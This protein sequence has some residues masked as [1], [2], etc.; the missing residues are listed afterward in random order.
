MS[1]KKIREEIADLEEAIKLMDEDG[2]DTSDMKEV[3]ANLKADLESDKETLKAMAKKDKAKTTSQKISEG[4][5]AK[6]IV[7]PKG[8]PKAVKD[9]EKIAKQLSKDS[10]DKKGFHKGQKIIDKLSVKAESKQGSKLYTYDVYIIQSDY[11]PKGDIYKGY[12]LS[13]DNTPATWL[14]STLKESNQSMD[15]ISIHG[16]DWIC[17]NFGEVMTELN[18]WIENNLKSTG[19]SP[20]DV[21]LTKD[22]QTF[23]GHKLE[24][25]GD[26]WEWIVSDT[27]S[28]NVKKKV[29]GKWAVTYEKTVKEF[30]TPVECFKYIADHIYKGEAKKYIDQKEKNKEASKEYAK[31]PETEK[32]ENTLEKTADTIENRVDEI[33]ASGDSVTSKQGREYIKEITSIIL[34]IKDGFSK[35]EERKSFIRQLI[36]QLQKE[37]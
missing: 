1:Q 19:K 8:T 17:T 31:V 36:K 13:I 20:K 33:K 9:I 6:K 28:Y 23:L 11:I 24:K 35:E 25:K 2:E 21:D 16:R 12:A 15:T 29:S 5:T 3:L 27:E 18:Q 22:K 26:G 10:E 14:I 7:Q 37:L 30:D 34:N 32:I 4:R